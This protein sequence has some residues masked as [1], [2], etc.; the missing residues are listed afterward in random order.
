MRIL[1]NILFMVIFV[2]ASPY[3][4]LRMRRRGNWQNG[5]GQRFGRYDAKFKQAITNR[6][7]LW[8]H[9]VSVGEVGICTQLIRARLE[10]YSP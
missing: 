9:A 3:Y 10:R 8:M 6:H 7:T 2:L 5:L 4:F 1:Y